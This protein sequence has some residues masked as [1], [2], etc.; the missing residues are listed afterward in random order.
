M[1]LAGHRIP[2]PWDISSIEHTP[3]GPDTYRFYDG[4]RM[5]IPPKID[6]NSYQP[7]PELPVPDAT[8][9]RRLFLNP[10]VLG[11]TLALWALIGLAIWWWLSG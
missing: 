1:P 2:N 3:G 10:I 4:H 7:D 6:V 9:R 8:G 5:A 11:A